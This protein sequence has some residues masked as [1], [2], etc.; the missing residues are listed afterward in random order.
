[1]LS[2]LF[3][4]RGRDGEGGHYHGKG[5]VERLFKILQDR[6]VKEMRLLGISSIQAA[7]KFL[8]TYLSKFNKQFSVKPANE[9]DLHRGVPA[10]LD[11]DKVLCIRTPRA[12]RNDFTVAHDKKLYQ[13]E[14]AVQ[15]NTVLVANKIDGSM[16]MSYQGKQLKIREILERPEKATPRKRKYKGW[17]SGAKRLI[18]PP[19]RLL[20]NEGALAERS[21][22]SRQ[23]HAA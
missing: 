21:P 22:A 17:K 16:V 20:R 18:I 1:V 11:L 3:Q 7:N 23:S 10:M 14:T 2:C 6:L 13:V 15:T 12:L 5:R 8:K 19:E 9:A 4:L